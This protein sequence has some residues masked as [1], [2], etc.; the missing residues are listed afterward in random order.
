MRVAALYDVHGNL[1]ALEAVLAEVATQSIDAIVC[2][3]D[4]VWGPRPGECLRRLR[5]AGAVFVRGNCERHLV[6][7]V[8]D[9]DRWSAEQL[10]ADELGFV[11]ALPLTVRLADVLYCHATPRDDDEILTRL[12]PDDAVAAALVGVDAGTVVFGHT[13]QQLERRVGGIRLVNAGSVGLPYEG[14][15]GAFW[16][17]VADEVELRRT[18][19]DVD[20]AAAD[21]EAVEFPALEQFAGPLRDPPPPDEA[22]AYFEARRG[23]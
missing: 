7:R 11:G 16:A 14:R 19:Y 4:V 23:S 2:G 15:R 21:A 3:G 1:P 9:V 18:E 5:A 8:S 20:A 22:A 12:T 10:T 13:H 6:E 17:I